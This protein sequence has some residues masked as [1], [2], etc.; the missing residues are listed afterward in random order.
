MLHKQLAA[1]I[2]PIASATGSPATMQER[3]TPTTKTGPQ[4][5]TSINDVP[6]SNQQ[7][8]SFTNFLASAAVIASAHGE[9]LC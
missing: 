8:L 1:V 5:A 4:P 2:A 7:Q 9:S 6:E 3:E